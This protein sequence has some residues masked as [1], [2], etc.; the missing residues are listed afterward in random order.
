MPDEPSRPGDSTTFWEIVASGAV[1]P[2]DAPCSDNELGPRDDEGAQSADG[3]G[4]A[5]RAARKRRRVVR[6]MD[7]SV[8][9]RPDR[10]AATARSIEPS[11]AVRDWV[12]AGDAAHTERASS[13]AAGGMRQDWAR[14][15]QLQL[16]RPP[17]APLGAATISR[18]SHHAANR[19][20]E[21]SH[22]GSPLNPLRPRTIPVL[23]TVLSRGR[24][25]GHARSVLPSG[26]TN[27]VVD[28][29]A[30]PTRVLVGVEARIAELVI[31]RRP[32]LEQLVRAAVDRELA[33]LVDAELA[34]DSAHPT[35][36]WCRLDIQ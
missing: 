19:R 22:D 36:S 33:A 17:R 24:A 3:S 15:A 16:E 1:A 23:C 13:K 8:D 28:S 14:S 18:Q 32:V 21:A 27:S 25:P 6:A 26:A 5:Y 35:F 10:E 4:F 2:G 7:T 11:A 34:S 30:C 31:A 12:D 29:T 9:L 20:R